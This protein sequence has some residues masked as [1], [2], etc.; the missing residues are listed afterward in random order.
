L[1][2]AATG[3]S[4]IT[5]RLPENDDNSNII[6]KLMRQADVKFTNL[7]VTTH[8]FEGYPSAISGGSWSV[9]QPD[10]LYDLK[11]YG[12]NL[13]GWAT[14]HALDFSYGGLKATKKN[15]DRYQFVH[16]GAGCNLSEASEPKYLETAHG[17]VALIS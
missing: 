3:D 16:A 2:V 10:V 6:Y 1:T 9:A 15:L 17:R 13:I 7:E 8:D 11:K 5:R 12:F 4:F 14:N